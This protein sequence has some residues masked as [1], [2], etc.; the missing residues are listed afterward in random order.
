MNG[1]KTRDTNLKNNPNYYSEMSKKRKTYSGGK[2]FV[3]VEVARAAQ[4]K[5]VESRKR[6]AELK[7]K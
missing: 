2:T 1:N 6:N 4:R 7:K 3:D 5:A